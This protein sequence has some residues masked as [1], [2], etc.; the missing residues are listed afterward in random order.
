MQA[1]TPNAVYSGHLEYLRPLACQSTVKD[2]KICG[3]QI[4]PGADP[5]TFRDLRMKAIR[6]RI[7]EMEARLAE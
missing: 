3:K 1:T 6:R 4:P 2:G 5:H 7:Q